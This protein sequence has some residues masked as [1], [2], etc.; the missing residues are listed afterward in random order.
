MKT[1]VWILFFDNKLPSQPEVE[2]VSVLMALWVA[3][4]GRSATSLFGNLPQRGVPAESMK[5]MILLQ[6]FIVKYF[7]ICVWTM[8]YLLNRKSGLSFSFDGFAGHP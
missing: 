7:L 5:Y 2:K 3:R 1:N 6:K 8:N 4:E